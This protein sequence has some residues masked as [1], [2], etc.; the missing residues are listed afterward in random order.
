MKETDNGLI[1][2]RRG[3]VVITQD[4]LPMF[5]EMINNLENRP[6]LP[7][8][9]KPK[10]NYEN[11]GLLGIAIGICFLFIIGAMVISKFI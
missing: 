3:E 4:Q 7:E 9:P 11:D 1:L 10:I 5:K 2:L 6:A 8:P